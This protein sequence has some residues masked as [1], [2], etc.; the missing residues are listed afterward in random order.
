MPSKTVATKDAAVFADA[1]QREEDKV[2]E[3]E[4]YRIIDGYLFIPHSLRHH[5]KREEPQDSPAITAARLARSARLFFHSNQHLREHL[6]PAEVETS[7]GARIYYERA[8]SKLTDIEAKASTKTQLQLERQI[9]SLVEGCLRD[10]QCDIYVG[11]VQPKRTHI[12][13]SACSKG[14]RMQ[15]QILQAS[16][17]LSFQCVESQAVVICEDIAAD[18]TIKYFGDQF[19]CGPF[20]CFPLV[21]KSRNLALNVTGEVIGVIGV[22]SCRL[23]WK[24][25]PQ[26]MTHEQVVAFLRTYGLEDCIPAIIKHQIDGVQLTALTDVDM[27]F[28]LGITRVLSRSKLVDIV[29]ALRDGVPLHVPSLPTWFLH[30]DASMEFL[31]QV[32]ARSGKILAK[33]RMREWLRLLRARTID[34]RCT[35]YDLY[36]L[37]LQAITH[38][39]LSV[40]AASVWRLDRGQPPKVHVLADCDIPQD[41]LAPFQQNRGIKRVLLHKEG[42]GKGN[43]VRGHV[44]HLGSLDGATPYQISWSDHTVEYF[45]WEELKPLLAIRP[46][47]P[48]HFELQ[49]ILSQLETQTECV[50]DV[51]GQEGNGGVKRWV[52]TFTDRSAST[53]V[54]D[55]TFQKNRSHVD[56]AYFVHQLLPPLE[57]A[58]VC[59]RGRQ[60]RAAQQHAALHVMKKAVAQLS[61]TPSQDA[62]R[63]ATELVTLVANEIVACLPGVEIAIAELL[64]GAAS[65]EFTYTFNGSTLATK[66]LTG[67]SVA[68]SCCLEAQQKS[69]VV[70]SFHSLRRIGK[71]EDDSALPYIFLPLVHDDSPLG[72]V[73]VN[74]FAEVEKGRD[75][76]QH[77]EYGVL[78]FLEQAT[79]CLAT[80]LRLK[81][82]SHALYQLQA[83]AQN[84]FVSPLQLFVTTLK[85]MIATLPGLRRAKLVAIELKSSTATAVL[86][87]VDVDLM[88]VL[89]RDALQVR[90]AETL[91]STFQAYFGLT[92]AIMEIILEPTPS[93]VLPDDY[94]TLVNPPTLATTIDRKA[95]H[96]MDAAMH[97]IVG[98]EPY[99]TSWLPALS[100]PSTNVVLMYTALTPKW[101]N[102]ADGRFLDMV[103]ASLNE[104]LVTVRG[105]YDRVRQRIDALTIFQKQCASTAT[106]N[107]HFESIQAELDAE[108]RLDLQRVAVDIIAR[109]LTGANVYIGMTEPSRQRIKYTCASEKSCMATKHLK[110]GKGVSFHCL[111]AQ[112]P[113]VIDATNKSSTEFGT[114][115]YFGDPKT[116]AWPFIVVPIGSFGV[117][118]VDDLSQY[119][120]SPPPEMGIVDFLVR[121][122]TEL[123][124][125]IKNTRETTQAYRKQLRERAVHDVLSI[126]DNGRLS[127]LHVLQRLLTIVAA[128]FPGVCAYTGL[129]MSWAK[130]I[131]FV[132]AT[133]SSEMEGRSIDVAKTVSGVCFRSQHPVVV[134][135]VGRNPNGLQVFKDTTGPYVCVPIPFV[136]IL[137]VDTFPS[138]AGGLYMQHVPEVGV[139]ECLVHMANAVGAHIRARRLADL[140]QMIQNLFQG[141]ISTFPILFNAIADAIVVNMASA[142]RVDV[143]YPDGTLKFTKSKTTQPDS[144]PSMPSPLPPPLVP[145]ADGVRVVCPFEMTDPKY[146]GQS[147]A[148]LVVTRLPNIDWPYDIHIM[149]TIQPHLSECFSLASAR[150]AAAAARAECISRMD[151]ALE[152]LRATPSQVALTKLHGTQL[153]WLDWM[154]LALGGRGTDVYLG[155]IQNDTDAL[156]FTGA[157]P[158]SLMTGIRLEDESLFS[159]QCIRTQSPVIVNHLTPTSRHVKF[160]TTRKATR[161]YCVVPLDSF[162]VLAADSFGSTSFTVQ[163]VLE[164]ATVAF[165]KT[166]ATKFVRLLDGTRHNFDFDQLRAAAVAGTHNLRM[167]YAHAMADIQRNL[168]YI[169]CQQ[170]VTL[171]PDFTGQFC[172]ESWHKAPTRRPMKH[173]QEHFCYLHR[174]SK[175]LVRQ[176]VH[177]DSVTIPMTN[178]P[179]T[180]DDARTH[181]SGTA[182]GIELRGSFPCFAA[183]LDGAFATTPRVALSVYRK[184]GR[185]FQPREVAFLRTYLSVVRESYLVALKHLVVRTFA[186]EALHWAR[187]FVHAKDGFVAQ[188]RE[189]DVDIL[190]STNVDKIALGTLKPTLKRTHRL[191]DFAAT[192]L[193]SALVET[194][195]TPLPSATSPSM[196][197]TQNPSGETTKRSKFALFPKKAKPTTGDRLSSSATVPV[198][199]VSQH[200]EWTCRLSAGRFLLLDIVSKN[201][202][203]QEIFVQEGNALAKTCSFIYDSFWNAPKGDERHVGFFL[204]QWWQQVHGMLAASRLAIER[205]LRELLD[206]EVAHT[207]TCPRAILIIASS[208]LLCCGHKADAMTTARAVLQLILSSESVGHMCDLDPFD[209][210]TRTKVWTAAFRSRTF[211]QSQPVAPIELTKELSPA[212]RILLDA[213]LLLQVV[214]KWLKA[215]FDKEKASW[216]PV[217]RAAV[218]IQCGARCMRARAELARRRRDFRAALTIQCWARQL[219]ARW[220]LQTKRR[221]RAASRIQRWFRRRHDKPRLAPKELLENMLAVQARFG[222]SEKPSEMFS[223][224]T[225][226]LFM[227]KGRGRSMVLAEEKRLVE[228]LRDL[229]KQR[230]SLSWEERIDE[231]VRDVFAYFDYAGVGSISREDTKTMIQKSRIPLQPDELDDVVAMIDVDKSGDVDVDEFCRWYKYEY[232]RLRARSKDCGTLSKADK[233]WFSHGMAL[234]FIKQQ[235]TACHSKDKYT[236]IAPS[237][238]PPLVPPTS[239]AEATQVE[240]PEDDKQDVS[241][242]DDDQAESQA[243][244]EQISSA[245]ERE[246]AESSAN[247]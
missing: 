65:V 133:P 3:A 26:A 81:R 210:S 146:S 238:A 211:L 157:S 45:T 113:L 105:R 209:P 220:C 121:M 124:V 143:L 10:G 178:L 213:T 46:L 25:H 183:M 189:K 75:D 83:L 195:A 1:I 153:A 224:A 174:C 114:L 194:T 72:F 32:A 229:A 21:S 71:P 228:K 176:R 212:M 6:Y 38:C 57:E 144:T 204:S 89:Y 177:F 64:P 148:L 66:T 223:E 208:A 188:L 97:V 129:V 87:R 214:S 164:A 52:K 147:H 198:S 185:S 104:L 88:D 61:M 48:H 107:A 128:T 187:D 102:R 191:Q 132:L 236:P 67:P 29:A 205:Q 99:V 44:A 62:Q 130:E 17:G 137:A 237:L 16:E 118:A 2:K 51:G 181:P 234:R 180:L 190:V 142:V 119:G 231:E 227:T 196:P 110:R 125:A 225:F 14:S 69:L 103:A 90:R 202:V 30:D 152:E 197:P 37:V 136:G 193:S 22:D 112:T 74:R 19:R 166:C 162:G 165:L 200:W 15:G 140:R 8:L 115:R 56:A 84:A 145:F 34:G 86:D 78:S 93:R 207:S 169:H 127:E 247:E 117:L 242:A 171:A 108:I 80:I 150:A 36:H 13:Y 77:P 240:S 49:Q 101:L 138:P 149:E 39:V 24:F 154:A 40:D 94:A 232:A 244:D 9:V 135:D 243:D 215:D 28:K 60:R 203:E 73:S 170:V 111:T 155:E 95:K 53:Y 122:A 35:Q 18:P 167:I 59:V 100:S 68:L 199:Q 235:W 192:D 151:M 47:N 50:V 221:S 141:N 159:F 161:A 239:P 55:M 91:L 106:V 219:L 233:E 116:Q 27:E 23:A 43:M 11:L 4:E 172:I 20:G 217:H 79:S 139:V 92:T 109:V 7:I 126:C 186:E 245:A 246:Q 218:A 241:Q 222:V 226:E 70:R 201:A 41:R 82:R 96:A 54:V 230:L 173:L 5:F 158:Q 33:A 12:L 63:S 123:H 134:P 98:N 163:N 168:G 184:P 85:S 42:G 58:L 120:E 182:M 216:V 76:E 131:H 206:A 31:T 175:A 179:K 160:C 156:V